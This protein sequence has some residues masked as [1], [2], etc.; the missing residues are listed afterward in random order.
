MSFPLLLC[1]PNLMSASTCFA[2]WRHLRSVAS[3]ALCCFIALWCSS[4]SFLVS[5]SRSSHSSCIQW[6]YAQISPL[7]PGLNQL[8]TFFCFLIAWLVSCTLALAIFGLGDCLL[9]TWTWSVVVD[10]AVDLA[11]DLVWLVTTLLPASIGII[12]SDSVTC[13]MW[14]TTLSKAYWPPRTGTCLYI[15]TVLVTS[16]NSDSKYWKLH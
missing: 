9:E 13:G 11:V 6:W 14:I 12:D 16:S 8:S 5:S 15:M 7:V 1:L 3:L 10:S 4:A 2:R